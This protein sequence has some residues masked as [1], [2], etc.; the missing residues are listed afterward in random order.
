MGKI[1]DLFVRLGLKKSE[2]DRGM[3]EAAKKASSFGSK[4]GT[5]LKGA[6]AG[7]GVVT[8]A[9]GV[10]AKALG[11]LS[12]QNQTLGDNWNRTIASM[13]A[14]W[15]SF[16]TDVANTD[17]TGAV[18]RARNAAAAA[19]DYYNAKDWETE[20]EQANRLIQAE[21]AAD[22]EDWQEIARDVNRS[23]KER[24]EAIQN[25][26]RTMEPV[27]ANT[28]AQNAITAEKS[29][30][31]F[32]SSA[33]GQAVET[34]TEDARKAWTDYVKWQGQVSNRAAVEAADV[35]N[36][37]KRRLAQV[38]SNEQIGQAYSA[39]GA[40]KY[41]RAVDTGP[42]RALIEAREALASALKD[43]KD[44][45]V[46]NDILTMRQQYNDRLNDDKT[47]TMV[48][49][50][51]KYLVSVAAEQRENRRLTTLLHS[52]EHKDLNGSIEAS[53]TTSNG[54][55]EAQR[56][57]A[58]T[59]AQQAAE[60]Q[61][62]E[63][64]QLKKHYEEEKALLEAFG[65]DTAMLTL[66]YHDADAELT[67]K[68]LDE[69]KPLLQDQLEDFEDSF[70]VELEP[71]EL[72]PGVQ[73]FLDELTALQEEAEDRAQRFKEALVGGFSAG[74]QEL[75]DQLMGLSEVNGGAIL[76]AL[77][78]PL[79]DMAQQE[80][81][82]L[83]MQGLGIEAIK[84]ALTSLNGVAAIAAGTALVAAAAAVKSGLSKI[85]Q[86]GG[87]AAGVA[88]TGAADVGTGL[89]GSVQDMELTVKIEGS[90]RGSDI[91]LAAQRTEANWSR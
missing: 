89:V 51:E 54:A 21:H 80:G 35:V 23:N 10:L 40:D 11:D 68:A 28:I 67:R 79:A 19:A 24:A 55:L 69:D 66:K 52:L 62:S 85:A 14:A 4:L 70:K 20:V 82:L 81:E 59:I 34:I 15:D 61:L 12:R 9:A 17:F 6:A 5:I 72:G 49:D 63:R 57:Q 56:R 36:A 41:G 8:V 38:E 29:L 86:S 25:I 16:K 22:I 78:T 45:G 43:A 30:N 84:S 58:E 74:I 1:G 83:I 32:I 39:M 31:K 2:F 18:K 42:S 48:G 46:T 33:T 53:A 50:V 71:F 91:V 65:I 73:E 75:T 88:T 77:L 7:F 26:M 13:K 64:T 60:Y 87:N 90:L 44:L 27:Y 3:D 37:A 47:Q 76:Q